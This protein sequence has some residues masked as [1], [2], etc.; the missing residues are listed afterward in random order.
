[1][2]SVTAERPAVE[3][4]RYE[5]AESYASRFDLDLLDSTDFSKLPAGIDLYLVFLEPAGP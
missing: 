4:P 1:L 2:K 3:L 5:T